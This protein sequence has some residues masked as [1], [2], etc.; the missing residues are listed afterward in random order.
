MTKKAKRKGPSRRSHVLPDSYRGKGL[1]DTL[2]KWAFRKDY[3]A[4]L[5]VFLSENT[6][7][8]PALVKRLLECGNFLRFGFWSIPE[9]PKP[10]LLNSNFCKCHLLCSN[11]AARRSAASAAALAEKFTVLL[12]LYPD[13]KL[14]FVTRTIKNGPVLT[15]RYLHLRS[16]ERK[17]RQMVRDANKGKYDLLYAE[18]VA[19]AGGYEITFN[20]KKDTWHPHTHESILVPKTLSAYELDTEMETIWQKITGDSFITRVREIDSST[21]DDLVKACCEILKYSFKQKGMTPEL[22]YQAYR[23]VKGKRLQYTFGDLFGFSFP[24]WYEPAD[25]LALMKSNPY[26][27]VTLKYFSNHYEW[28]RSEQKERYQSDY[29]FFNSEPEN[30][31]YERLRN[32]L[33]DKYGIP[34][35]ATI[36]EQERIYKQQT[37]LERK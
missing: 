14:L 25:I 9:I 33:L 10:K 31:K 15:E 21:P 2:D 4:E 32:E 26:L 37:A 30:S 35:D 17:L 1:E 24:D 13:H 12:K 3:T 5:A 6:D 22:Q 28:I 34:Y 11:C 7:E 27:E 29:E 36:E 20:A 19:G 8:D 16:A 18:A 23:L